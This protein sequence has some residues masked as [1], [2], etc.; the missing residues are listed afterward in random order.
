MRREQT[1][2]CQQFLDFISEAKLIDM[3]PKQMLTFNSLIRL[4][5]TKEDNEIDENFFQTLSSISEEDIPK[6][7]QDSFAWSSERANTL[8]DF[9]TNF[10]NMEGL[11]YLEFCNSSYLQRKLPITFFKLYSGI[12]YG[13]VNGSRVYNEV[14]RA[15]SHMLHY[16]N[17]SVL[18]KDLIF[19]PRLPTETCYLFDPIFRQK[20]RG[21]NKANTIIKEKYFT[22]EFDIRDFVYVCIWQFIP[23]VGWRWTENDHSAHFE[24]LELI[25][26]L[27]EYGLWKIEDV[28]D[29]L[30]S[31]Y[32]VSEIMFNLENY[33]FNERDD[34]DDDYLKEQILLCTK[35]RELIASCFMHIILLYLDDDVNQKFMHFDIDMGFSG[36]GN[37]KYKDTDFDIKKIN[38]LFKHS[39]FNKKKLYTYFSYVLVTYLGRQKFIKTDFPH[40]GSEKLS[41]LLNLLFTYISDINGDFFKVSL[42]MMKPENFPFYLLNDDSDISTEVASFK[43]RLDEMIE[44]VKTERYGQLNIDYNNFL[45]NL[46]IIFQEIIT[47]IEEEEDSESEKDK[48]QTTRKLVLSLYNIPQ[49]ILAFLDLIIQL[50]IQPDTIKVF[51][52]GISLI[53][54]LGLENYAGFNMLFTGYNQFHIKNLYNYNVNTLTS[55]TKEFILNSNSLVLVEHN[56]QILGIN[57]EVYKNMLNSFFDDFNVPL[58][59]GRISFSKLSVKNILA[60][61]NYNKILSKLLENFITRR[62]KYE[63]IISDILKD[64]VPLFFQMLKGERIEDNGGDGEYDFWMDIHSDQ[65]IFLENMS[66]WEDHPSSF[67]RM[68][69]LELFWTFLEL[70]NRCTQRFYSDK[71]LTMMTE[72]FDGDYKLEEFYKYLNIKVG[73][74]VVSQFIRCFTNFMIFRQNHLINNRFNEFGNL[75]TQTTE[76]TLDDYLLDSDFRME[77]SGV[78]DWFLSYLDL[79][80]FNKNANK[81]LYCSY[82]PMLFKYFNGLFNMFVYED[83]KGMEKEF[84]SLIEEIRMFEEFINQ[85]DKYKEEIQGPFLFPQREKH[86][87]KNFETIDA[88][89]IKY[90]K[91]IE[92]DQDNF[93]YDEKKETELYN[94]RLAGYKLLIKIVDNYEGNNKK[95]YHLER[96]I[97]Y[98]P[99]HVTTKIRKAM[100]KKLRFNYLFRKK[101]NLKDEEAEYLE[102]IENYSDPDNVLRIIK[103]FYKF[104]KTHFFEYPE[105]NQC[106]IV[107]KTSDILKNN[108]EYFVEYFFTEISKM[109]IDFQDLENNIMINS[110]YFSIILMMDNL[111][112]ISDDYREKIYDML[113]G[114]Y[115][116]KEGDVNKIT[117]FKKIWD[118]H[119]TLYYLSLYK[120]FFDRDWAEIFTLYYLL[121][122]F[123]QNLCEDNFVKF[124]LWFHENDLIKDDNKSLFMYYF[125]MF[126]AAFL[127]SRLHKNK[128]SHLSLSDKPE[129]L[130]I[131]NRL[132]IGM[133]EFINGGAVK[134]QFEIYKYKIDVWVGIILRVID[135]ID[136]EF[137]SL[138]EN[139]LTFLLG[140]T[141]GHD[142]SIIGFMATNFPITRLYSLIHK[143]IKKLYI[144]QFLLKNSDGREEEP[145]FDGYTVYNITEEDEINHS[146]KNS[147]ILLDYY[148]RYEE[149]FS[150]HN[151][152]S[153][154]IKI[155]TLMR[156]LS[157]HIVRYD[158]FIIA[159]N[160]DINSYIRHNKSTQQNLE[161]L[162]VWAF[163]KEIIVDIEINYIDINDEQ[164]RKEEEEKE[165]PPIR[166]FYFKKL[167]QCFF[168]TNAAKREFRDRVQIDSLEDK[169]EQFFDEVQ[170]YII[171]TK[172]LQHLFKKSRFLFRF[173]TENS[174]F[175]YQVI[176]YSLAI[177]LNILLL[178][179][180]EQD[181]NG[182]SIFSGKAIFPCVIVAG[183]IIV[184]S[185]IF[186]LFWFIVRYPTEKKIAWERYYLAHL[187]EKKPSYLD[188]YLNNVYESIFRV[189]A[190][191]TFIFSFLFATLGLTI[192]NYFYTLLLFLIIFISI[193]VYNVVLSF[194]INYDKLFFTLLII[195]VV[196]N[197]FSY[198]V[199]RFFSKDFSSDDIGDDASELCP[200]YFTCAMNSLNLGLRGGGGISDY[201]NLQE[202]TN[203]GAFYGRFFFDIL[204]FIF[205][206]I[207]LLGIF[208][209][210]IVDSFKELRDNIT[211]RQKDEADICFT[212][213]LERNVLERKGINFEDHLEYHDIW[214]YFFYIIYLRWKPNNDYDGVDIY[215]NEHV[216]RDYDSGWLPIGRTLALKN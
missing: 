6:I 162:Y 176:L 159:K 82:Y 174:L 187:K 182:A 89:M 46:D 172:D 208:F 79:F 163:L 62:S 112:Q 144:R 66:Y 19:L 130:F 198:L 214:N 68:Y 160:E 40:I 74:D 91:L 41:N 171:V 78:T 16:F 146:I 139:I 70:F 20:V 121:S 59:G 120:T 90:A 5:E 197:S 135:D 37:S 212:C 106:F 126:E 166:I 123:L 87:Y 58:N 109:D 81:F 96:Y 137:Y 39:T 54:K 33:I 76:I 50:E 92:A 27:F 136:S 199:A 7:R 11:F 36:F 69:L 179:Y 132:T 64:Y 9:F 178:Y 213:G 185:F 3:N 215:V 72:L 216:K 180:Y 129:L 85:V 196:I 114:R 209:G 205:V 57:L 53:R 35:C 161:P 117:A 32:S 206:N 193:L 186:G 148:K 170:Q 13:R 8:I 192:N 21:L 167:P 153:V 61:Y 147:E 48:D 42:K 1:P 157:S 110:N 140:L 210:I 25:K 142:K 151:I 97:R 44:F 45:E 156:D 204:F 169:H 173:S 108:I 56:P 154:V 55:L 67:K 2:V 71:V 183:L 149:S 119:K 12:N 26:I 47:G 29:L 84:K 10:D 116:S 127:N 22:D 152:L 194:M 175:S 103:D 80:G 75:E 125:T 168:L 207:I 95:L 202:D 65:I 52:S 141:E 31:L 14:I 181:F 86:K 145:N 191:Q 100:E 18:K 60:L 158:N 188:Y 102:S 115:I 30:T 111:I 83:H 128:T 101:L 122:N 98:D 77:I 195:L 124:K 43:D 118:L 211:K 177:A 138:K 51:N 73:T 99:V 93:L 24:T 15:M 88:Y 28:D 189:R 165:T 143:L 155:Y 23:N 134:T 133:T 38:S 49:Y 113:T 104:S 150:D 105:Q 34:V 200:S 63:L 94:L 184:L 131:L 190:I 201:M 107:L 17:F 203:K 164:F 4:L